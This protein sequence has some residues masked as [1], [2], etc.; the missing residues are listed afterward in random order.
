[1]NKYLKRI[2]TFALSCLLVTGCYSGNNHSYLANK[3]EAN[4]TETEIINTPN[5]TKQDSINGDVSN[6]IENKI[7]NYRG[8]LPDNLTK[9]IVSQVYSLVAV[10]LMALGYDV[11][12]AYKKGAEWGLAYTDY[13]DAYTL[14]KEGNENNIDYIG[15]GF[16]SFDKINKEDELHIDP[17]YDTV[18]PEEMTYSEFSSFGLFRLL[19][20]KR[21]EGIKG[22]YV[23]NQRYIKYK[24]VGD[25]L[26]ILN[27]EKGNYDPKF[28]EI[29]D[30]D[31]NDYIFI[32]LS[33]IPDEVTTIQMLVNPHLDATNLSKTFDAMMSKQEINAYTESYTSTLFLS[34]EMFE[35]L[36]GTLG[37]QQTLNN[38]LL[39]TINSIEY[40]PTKQYLS[41]R[42][43]GTIGV[44]DIP[45]NL[46]Y[47]KTFK[48][49]LIDSLIVAGGTTIA[50]CVTVF[51]GGAGSMIS[52]AIMG[53][54]G[55]YAT[56]AFV[57]KKKFSEINVGKILI[58][59]VI[60]A[61][62]AGIPVANFGGGDFFLNA[63]GSGLI[64][65]GG[66]VVTNLLDG[67]RDP[68]KLVQSAA[69]Q[70]VMG[71]GFYSIRCLI[72][73]TSTVEAHE[74]EEQTIQKINASDYSYLGGK[75]GSANSQP[76]LEMTRPLASSQSLQNVVSGR[77]YE[78]Y[79]NNGKELALDMVGNSTKRLFADSITSSMDQIVFGM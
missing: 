45:P 54:V 41:M 60:G 44:V 65:A 43:D 25:A 66:D 51:T 29:F 32:P 34:V 27:L 67:E 33:Q 55:N 39:E 49:W 61:L 8:P 37:Q 12:S 40:D 10:D 5:E 71:V 16:I 22:Q 42:D 48:E 14:E 23:K 1:M 72:S 31:Q 63:L 70:A 13:S 56:Q 24:L 17:T 52:G 6:E 20:T 59:S 36:N 15:C 50:I 57:Y 64:F 26:I 73:G 76:V 74:V 53:A 11:I 2:L 47:G 21:I 79:M 62:T 19:D 4:I 58:A 46:L 28:G 68:K 3:K 30:Y 7:N 69:I 9:E 77:L 75:I 78:T 18:R 38:A 35:F